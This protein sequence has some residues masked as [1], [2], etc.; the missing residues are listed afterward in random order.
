VCALAVAA[1]ADCLFTHDRGYLSDGLA[2]YRVRVITPDEFLAP[3]FDPD[4]EEC[5]Q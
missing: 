2:R 4:P 5:S 1:N 3:A